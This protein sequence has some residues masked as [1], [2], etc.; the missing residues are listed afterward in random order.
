MHCPHCH[1]FAARGQERPRRRGV[2]GVIGFLFQ[3]VFLYALLVFG[4]GTLINTGH[5]VA[6][7]VGRILQLV[8]FVE[9]TIYWAQGEGYELAAEGLRTLANGVTL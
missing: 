7:E 1:D 9:P 3:V 4:G 5:P 8:T 2:G 6:M